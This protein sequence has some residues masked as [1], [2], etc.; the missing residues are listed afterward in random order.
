M[1]PMTWRL[2]LCCLTCWIVFWKALFWLKE[3]S[4]MAKLIS[5]KF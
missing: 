1:I 3:P 4:S 2:E 5:D